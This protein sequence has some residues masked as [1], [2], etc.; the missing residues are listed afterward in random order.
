V[1][2]SLASLLKKVLKVQLIANLSK[3]YLSQN[4]SLKVKLKNKK[5]KRYR[6]L[7]KAPY[8]LSTNKEKIAK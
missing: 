8:Q 2:S 6:H 4:L 5:L 3:D 7:S 1:A